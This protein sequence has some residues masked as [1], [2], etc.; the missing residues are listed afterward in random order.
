M[1]LAQMTSGRACI[2]TTYICQQGFLWCSF[3]RQH[4]FQILFVLTPRDVM[5]TKS[6]SPSDMYTKGVTI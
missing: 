5:Y 6:V 1:H 2:V 3:G 4:Q